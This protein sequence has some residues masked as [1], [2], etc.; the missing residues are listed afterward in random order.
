LVRPEFSAF[1]QEEQATIHLV[2]DVA[3]V[4]ERIAANPMHTPALYSGF[5]RALISAKMDTNSAPESRPMSQHG[6]QPSGLQPTNPPQPNGF[7]LSASYEDP[8][9]FLLNDYQFESEMG[10]VADMSTFPPTMGAVPSD[11]HMGGLKMDSILS[12]AFWDSVLVPGKSV[13]PSS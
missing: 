6:G 7:S 11:P 3:D 13:F 4:L 5:L 10:P 12:N 8:S 1:L 9:S 2:R